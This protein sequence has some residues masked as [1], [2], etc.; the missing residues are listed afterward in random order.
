MALQEGWMT[1]PDCSLGG[2]VDAFEPVARH[3]T[4]WTFEVLRM[5]KNAIHSFVVTYMTS[6]SI[7]KEGQDELHSVLKETNRRLHL[8][9]QSITELVCRYIENVVWHHACHIDGPLFDTFRRHAD[10]P[11]EALD[12]L[13]NAMLLVHDTLGTNL[14][15]WIGQEHSDN[16]HRLMKPISQTCSKHPCL[17]YF[18]P[19]S[20]STSINW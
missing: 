11:L 3:G 1:S 2:T 12:P 20:V 16:F 6:L 4:F 17:C 8:S 7:P 9:M 10:E 19:E 15:F 13:G 14:C 5:Y 18:V